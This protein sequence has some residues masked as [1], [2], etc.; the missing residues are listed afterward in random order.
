MEERSS[1]QTT[2]TPDLKAFLANLDMFYLGTASSSGQ[3]YIQYRGGEPGFLKVIDER[4]LGFADFRGNRQYIS[5]GNLSEN[6]KAFLFLIDYVNRRR[7]KLWGTA[8]VIEG[9]SDL[10]Q[11][12]QDSQYPGHVE[13]VVLFHIKAWDI[14]CPQHI[15][16]RF[17]QALVTEV[18]E[19]LQE[20]IRELE[21]QL[22]NLR[23]D[24]H[25]DTSNVAE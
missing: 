24:G 10:L 18:V 4:T 22:N 2:V 8:E 11:Q 25:Q 19:D 5:Q 9:D 20:R 7:V 13:R 3:P 1:W 15:H 16:K 21:D 6:P 23:N 17:P 14:N 12:V